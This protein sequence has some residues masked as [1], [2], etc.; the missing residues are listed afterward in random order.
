MSSYIQAVNNQ[1]YYCLNSRPLDVESMSSAICSIKTD[2][3][4]RRELIDGEIFYF[5]AVGG[6]IYYVMYADNSG[7]IYVMKT[8]GSGSKKLLV[9]SDGYVVCPNIAGGRIY[10]FGDNVGNIYSIKTDGSDQQPV[11]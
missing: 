3:S 7:G 1:I 10:Y 8:D 11:T 9:D 6:W 2:G 4:D 5:N